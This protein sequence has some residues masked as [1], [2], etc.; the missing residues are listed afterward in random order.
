VSDLFQE[1]EDVTPLTIEEKRELIP[2]HIAFRSELNELEQEN[3]ARA[4]DWALGR[5]RVLLTEK[6]I[7]DLH[8]RMLGDMRRRY[9]AALQA[10]DR[11][12]IAALLVFARS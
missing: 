3:I 12:D 8:R 5:R 1:P 11:H 4:Q 7:R 2:S 10:A 6:F 9:I